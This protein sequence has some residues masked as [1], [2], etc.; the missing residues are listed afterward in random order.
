MPLNTMPALQ[1]AIAKPCL[2]HQQKELL[3]NCAAW[4]RV[5]QG[6]WL[7]GNTPC[8]TMHSHHSQSA[9]PPS[10]SC[11]SWGSKHSISDVSGHF[12][13]HCTSSN[14]LLPS[15]TKA[16]TSE[17]GMCLS[18]H[19]ETSYPSKLMPQKC[20]SYCSLRRSGHGPRSDP[21]ASNCSRIFSKDPTC[22]RKLK[23]SF[24]LRVM[25][26]IWKQW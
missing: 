16:S 23:K 12:I 17:E 3:N 26:G 21:K 18:A 13:N 9:S 8:W 25:Q 5:C 1:V 22:S 15:T 19:I 7:V 20:R 6:I 14:S 24:L 11:K 2:V 10:N 4:R